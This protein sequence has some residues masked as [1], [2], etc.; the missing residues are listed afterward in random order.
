MLISCQLGY[1]GRKAKKIVASRDI[2]YAFTNIMANHY[3]SLRAYNASPGYSDTYSVPSGSYDCFC[4]FDHI[5]NS[6]KTSDDFAFFVFFTFKSKSH[7]R[8]PILPTN[9]NS[10]LEAVAFGR[11]SASDDQRA[12]V[13]RCVAREA[14]EPGRL[15]RH[16]EVFR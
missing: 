12:H 8:Y 9:Q 10:R 6:T 1:E 4:F 2:S 15:V 14:Q 13:V 7:I 3:Y 11:W 16:L 5:S